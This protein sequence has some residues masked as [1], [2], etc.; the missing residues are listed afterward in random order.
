MTFRPPATPDRLAPRFMEVATLMR[1]PL[2]TSL[3][4]T[5]IGLF[6][7]PYDGALTNRAGARHGPREI[8]NQSSLVRGINHATRVA[9]FDLARIRDMGDVPFS[10]LFDIETVHANIADFCADLVGA[11]IVPFGFGGDHSVS[12]PLLRTVA[13]DGPVALLHVDAHTDT[14]AAMMGSKFN[15]GSPFRRTVHEERLDPAKA[16]TLEP[17]LPLAFVNQCGGQDELIFDGGCFVAQEGKVAAAAPRP[18]PAPQGIE[19]LTKLSVTEV[20]R[21]IR[22]PYAIY[23]RRILGL[24]RLDPLRA[25]PDARLRGTA[26]HRILEVFLKETS[27]ALPPDAEDI[28]GK[29]AR[30]VLADE[31]PWP[32]I[33]RL[34][35]AKLSGVMPWYLEKEATF[36]ALAD[37]WMVESSHEWEVPG[38]SLTLRGKADR[39]DR[40]S[41]G[42]VAIY[43]YK[44]GAVPSD[45][46]ARH[47]NKQLWLEALM[48]QGGAFAG[49]TLE[50]SRLAYVGL[51]A[52]PDLRD[53]DVNPTILAEIASGL[54]TVITHYRLIEVGFASRRAPKD[55]R[56]DGD[57]DHL[58][59]YGEWDETATPTV[60]PVGG[61][62]DG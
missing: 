1:A 59:R 60:I 36:R 62:H 39:I 15:H 18:A 22:D 51:G 31:A 54:R 32:A 19:R 17:G 26:I 3:E 61:S 45:K 48:A 35:E 25:G 8:R 44:T 4:G 9:P 23:A 43:D 16:R 40:L 37:P 42:S 38:L 28:F 7:I 6:G 20:E 12:L 53:E 33:R 14:N 2:A 41:D 24:R 27:D 50:V 46:E 13:K 11:G 10:S 47:F 55:T 52:K 56:Y 34:W 21:L 29:I 57:Y 58:A 30:D 5:D 49:Q